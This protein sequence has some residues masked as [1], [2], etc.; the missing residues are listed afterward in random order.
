MKSAPVHLNSEAW[1]FHAILNASLEAPA[2]RNRIVA[3]ADHYNRA[4]LTQD[5]LEGGLKRLTEAGWVLK[6]G[7]SFSGTERARVA[8]VRIQREQLNCFEEMDRLQKLLEN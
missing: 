4:V 3:V 6:E 5:E 2:D 1:L 8:Y 7:F